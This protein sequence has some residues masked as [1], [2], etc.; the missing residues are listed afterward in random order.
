MPF[1]NREDSYKLLSDSVQLDETDMAKFIELP[2]YEAVLVYGVSSPTDQAPI[3]ADILKSSAQVTEYN[4]VVV[5][6]D[7]DYVH[8]VIAAGNKLLLCNS[9]PSKDNVT[10][11]Y[12]IFA[13]MREFQINPELTIIHLYGEAPEGIE[14]DLSGYFQG[15]KVLCA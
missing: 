4:K 15:V 13:T 1:F 11:A 14:D 9:F 3:V 5:S 12:F 10:S 2:E 6:I 7:R 8:I